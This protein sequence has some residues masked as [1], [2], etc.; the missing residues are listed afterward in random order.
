MST[1]A[2]AKMRAELET[3]IDAAGL[4]ENVRELDEQGYTIFQDPV[5]HALTDRVRE[6]I[7]RLTQETEGPGKGLITGLL[8]GRDPVFDEAVLI[9]RLQVIVEYVVGRGARLFQLLGSVHRK[10]SPSIGLHADTSWFPA[11][12]PEWDFIATACWVTDSY[13]KEG[14]CTLIVPGSHRAA[15][16]PSPEMRRTL[17]GGVP[18]ECDKGSLVIWNSRA[19]HSNYPR[20]IDGERVVLHMSFSRI[21]IQPAEDYRHLGD[22]YLAGKPPELATLVGR[23]TFFGSTTTTSGGTDA[24]LLKQTYEF[25]HGDDFYLRP[26][27]E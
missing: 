14:G 15:A 12:F 4:R 7:L 11:P 16:H 27:D 6:A 1:D 19:W 5:A 17:E 2:L 22:D 20:T 26:G 24:D 8:L 21:G 3:R 13:T 10:G 9:P 18:I 23:N 25:V